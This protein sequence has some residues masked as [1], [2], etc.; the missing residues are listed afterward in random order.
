MVGEGVELRAL[1]EVLG[2]L[3]RERVKAEQL[4]ELRELLVARSR[5]I[6]PEEVITLHVVTD[7]RFVDPREARHPKAKLLAGV[8]RGGCLRLAYRHGRLPLSLLATHCPRGRSAA[9][10]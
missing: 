7:A 2:V 1:A 9:S 5:E 3:Q 8:R 4:M 10:C 6:Q